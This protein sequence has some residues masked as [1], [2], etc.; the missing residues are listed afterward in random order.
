M[1]PSLTSSLELLYKP[2]GLQHLQQKDVSSPTQGIPPHPIFLN[3]SHP[4]SFW[5]KTAATRSV[6][7]L[8][9]V[10]L[11]R[12]LLQLIL[13]FSNDLREKRFLT[14]SIPLN[15]FIICTSIASGCCCTV[16]KNRLDPQ[17][18]IPSNC[19]TGIEITFMDYHAVWMYR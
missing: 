14:F 19:V 12:P 10:E 17:P 9:T 7:V 6:R 18:A 16:S 8:D 4:L 5:R 2:L 11:L 3:H 13:S 15:G 1:T